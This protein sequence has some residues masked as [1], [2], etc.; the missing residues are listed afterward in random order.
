MPKNTTSDN[1]Y[2][3]TVTPL[4]VVL[5]DP[6]IISKTINTGVI[7]NI[8]ETRELIVN[9]E[10]NAEFEVVLS[11]TSG[12]ISKESYTIDVTGKKTIPIIFDSSDA[13]ETYTLKINS[14]TGTDVDTGFGNQTVTLTRN[15]KGRKTAT[16]LVKYSNTVNNTF[17]IEDYIGQGTNRQFTFDLTLPAGTYTIGKQ[18]ASTDV[19]LGDNDN[20]AFV[21]LNNIEFDAVNTNVLTVSGTLF[22]SDFQEDETYTL[23]ISPFVGKDVTTT[24][25]SSVNASDGNPAGNFTIAATS[26]TV[27][28]GSGLNSTPAETEYFFTLTPSA[29][30]EFD[31]TIDADDFELLDTSNNNVTS[32]YAANGELLLRKVGDTIEVGFKSK[33]FIQ[34]SATSTFTLRPKVGVTLTQA[35]VT[36]NVTKYTLK[37]NI[38]YTVDGVLSDTGTITRSVTNFDSTGQTLFPIYQ[39]LSGRINSGAIDTTEFSDNTLFYIDNTNNTEVTLAPAGS[40]TNDNGDAVTTTAE[41]EFTPS[42]NILVTNLLVDLNS[43]ATISFNEVD[44]YTNLNSNKTIDANGDVITKYHL[45]EVK[46]AGCSEQVNGPNQNDRSWSP[47]NESSN[48]YPKYYA[49]NS[50]LN[51]DVRIFVRNN[52][53]E[54]IPG[55]L[56]SFTATNLIQK[57][58]EKLFTVSTKNITSGTQAGWLFDKGVCSLDGSHLKLF[59]NTK[60]HELY[61]DIIKYSYP[62]SSTI[63]KNEKQTL[64][65]SIKIDN[66]T[67]Y[68]AIVQ[69]ISSKGFNIKPV[70]G[71]SIDAGTL[72]FTYDAYFDNNGNSSFDFQLLRGSGEYKIDF[73][74]DDVTADSTFNKLSGTSYEMRRRSID[75]QDNNDHISQATLNTYN[76]IEDY[77]TTSSLSRYDDGSGDYDGTANRITTNAPSGGGAYGYSGTVADIKIIPQQYLDNNNVL[78]F[79]NGTTWSNIMTDDFDWVLSSKAPA[80]IKNGTNYIRQTYITSDGP[81]TGKIDYTKTGYT[82]ILPNPGASGDLAAFLGLW[83]AID[84]GTVTSLKIPI[85]LIMP[86]SSYVNDPTVIPEERVSLDIAGTLINTTT[87]G[88]GTAAVEENGWW[89]ITAGISISN[90]TDRWKNYYIGGGNNVYISETQGPNGLKALPNYSGIQFTFG[91]TMPTYI[92]NIRTMAFAKLPFRITGFKNIINANYSDHYMKNNFVSYYEGNNWSKSFHEKW[93]NS[94]TMKKLMNNRLSHGTWNGA[95]YLK[96]KTYHS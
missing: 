84:Q 52:S 95:R 24:F 87:D 26:Y 63:F 73:A 56:A 11:D 77:N 29:T 47:I 18:P 6:K 83:V 91:I 38:K 49:T 35:E 70:Q 74:F 39:Y 21:L 34:P 12:L 68:D 13:A 44:I 59:T 33:T 86:S 43:D 7:P 88:D 40:Y 27:D 17:S 55:N 23:D 79:L 32:D 1:N 64:T 90:R 15:Q 60:K 10:Q 46:L 93:A 75:D 41:Y 16:F 4:E 57:N 42:T 45:V 94:A 37:V 89:P 58:N 72:T 48:V 92:D 62:I 65:G 81:L 22:V 28:G 67:N 78:E 54:T 80:D 9:G 3:I 31:S 53:N 76:V 50:L 71:A 5:P 8:S 36:T 66:K 20:G 96:F 30:Y 51:E 69:D 14:L 19:V 82:V 25:A 61:N 2:T 85:D